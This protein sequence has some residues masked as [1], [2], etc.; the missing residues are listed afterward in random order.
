MSPQVCSSFPIRAFPPARRTFSGYKP[1]GAPTRPFSTLILV[2]SPPARMDGHV[3]N[4]SA[5]STTSTIVD[6][7][8]QQSSAS[9]VVDSPVTLANKCRPLRGPSLNS[10]QTVIPPEHKYRTLVLCFD[11]TGDQFCSSVSPFHAGCL[12]R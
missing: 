10:C 1:T 8:V 6:G 12:P 5:V 2:P 11:G 9:T 7:T 3:K 4:I